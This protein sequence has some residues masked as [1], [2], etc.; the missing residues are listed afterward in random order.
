MQCPT[1]AHVFDTLSIGKRAEPSAFSHIPVVNSASFSMDH[2]SDIAC[3]RYC[4]ICVIVT[5]CV[6]AGA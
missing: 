1:H 4:M 5:F 3:G 6:S 2:A